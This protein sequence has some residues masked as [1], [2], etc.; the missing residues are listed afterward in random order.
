M[1]FTVLT[2]LFALLNYMGSALYQLAGGFTTV[3]PYSG[4]A[5]ALILILGDS[6]LVP[7]LV[8]GTLGGMIAKLASS[9][10]PFDLV[11][12]PCVT[13]LTVF[14]VYL[15]ARRLIGKQ[16]DFRA[17]HQLVGYIG[18][19]TLLSCISATTFTLVIDGLG[20]PH[21]GTYWQ[22][23]FIPTALSYVIFTP[24]I[25]LLATA[26]R[27]VLL[28]N[29]RRLCACMLLMG[30]VLMVNFLP[31]RL[32]ML[33]ATPMA[34]L[35]VTLVAGLEGA[36][37]GLVLTLLILTGATALGYGASAIS[38]LSLGYQLY[39]VQIFLA[40]LIGVMLPVAAAVAERVK[41]R[42][43]ME[44][45]LEREAQVNIALRASE[46]RAR[47]MAQ[48]CPSRPAKPSQNFSPA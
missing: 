23:W 25:V 8:A 27:A 39:F 19:S 17:W 43:S 2:V 10:G 41:L 11:I 13:S 22:A 47:D 3:K 24:V 9:A 16:V 38:Y 12:T 7:V 42:D 37:L 33:F 26:E 14:I 45:A 34:L 31:V 40:I 32:P 21:L 29:W 36:A 4:V 35:I 5:L 6:W 30:A 20:R 48:S 44:Q 18:L 28:G 1:T 15:A 46:Q